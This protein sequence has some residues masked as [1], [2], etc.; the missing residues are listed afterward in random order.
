VQS[1]LSA[2][3]AA[4][5]VNAALEAELAKEPQF[6]DYPNFHKNFTESLAIQYKEKLA[7]PTL[8]QQ[9]KWQWGNDPEKIKQLAAEAFRDVTGSWKVF[10]AKRFQSRSKEVAPIL[11]AGQAAKVMGPG[12]QSPV[13]AP[14]Q[15]KLKGMDA[16]KAKNEQYLRDYVSGVARETREGLRRS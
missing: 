14:E 10:E 9:E 2:Q 5:S 1:Q 15:T 6:R 7:D 16:Q 8:S 11:K 12:G 13:I 3:G 4:Q